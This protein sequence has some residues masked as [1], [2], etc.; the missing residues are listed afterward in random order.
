MA[1]FGD[2]T[3]DDSY[4]AAGQIGSGIGWDFVTIGQ[5]R[6]IIGPIVE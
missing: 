4:L 6:Q 2:T 5:D 3:I 1:Y